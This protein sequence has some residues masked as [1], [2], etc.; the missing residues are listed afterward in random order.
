VTPLPMEEVPKKQTLRE[1]LQQ[2]SVEQN[3]EKLRY[4]LEKI[5]AAFDRG[6]SP[7]DA[8]SD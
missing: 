5:A 2:A 8:E 1:L 4:L 3:H 6:E 7:S